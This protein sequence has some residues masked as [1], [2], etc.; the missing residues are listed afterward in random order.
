MQSA[1]G[2]FNG[3]GIPDVITAVENSFPGFYAG[4]VKTMGEWFGTITPV[5]Q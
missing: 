4:P 1:V 5:S 2:D 3:D